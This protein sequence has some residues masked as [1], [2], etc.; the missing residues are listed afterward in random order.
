M[1]EQRRLADILATD[2]VG[3]SRLMEDNERSTIVR[4][5]AQRNVLNDPK[6]AEDIGRKVKTKGNG[7]LGNA[8]A[9][10]I[11]RRPKPQL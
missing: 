4:Q 1:D 11:D 3:F 2:I 7:L 10:N 6:I 8:L 5:K 9:I